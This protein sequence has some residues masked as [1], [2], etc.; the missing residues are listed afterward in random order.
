MLTTCLDLTQV[1]HSCENSSPCYQEN[2]PQRLPG[3]GKHE[4]GDGR[5]EGDEGAAEEHRGR[6][7]NS[8][9]PKT[10]TVKCLVLFFSS[11]TYH[12]FV[13]KWLL[14][15][16]WPLSPVRFQFPDHSGVFT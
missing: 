12:E 10:A 13:L 5:A 6:H 15:L 11:A 1:Y 14:L 2:D 7:L 3:D 8:S 16:G 4:Q 9:S